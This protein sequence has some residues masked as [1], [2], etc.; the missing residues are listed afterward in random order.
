MHTATS[1]A[2]GTPPSELVAAAGG[3]ARLR[4]LVRQGHGVWRSVARAELR[5]SGW[6]TAGSGGGGAV[7][8]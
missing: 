6:R 3:A 7:L 1:A 4:G 2:E 8:L 5:A